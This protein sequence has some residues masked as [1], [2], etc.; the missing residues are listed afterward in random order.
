MYSYGPPHMAKQKQDDQLEHT[1]SSYVRIRDVAL[2]T[3]QKRWMIGRS[4]ERGSG[5]S[6]LA[7]RHDDGDDFWVQFRVFFFLNQLMSSVCLIIW[8]EFAVGRAEN[9][10]VHAFSKGILKAFCISH[11]CKKK[12]T[13]SGLELGS[14]A[15]FSM[16]IR[17]NCLHLIVCIRLLSMLDLPTVVRYMNNRACGSLDGKAGIGHSFIEISLKSNAAINA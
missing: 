9:S 5:I 11:K 7:A 10:W 15:P 1:Y 16:T 17:H 12:K 2:K 4:G 13:L 14:P 3:C 8:L 6:V